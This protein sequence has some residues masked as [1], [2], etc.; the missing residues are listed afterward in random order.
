M[1]SLNSDIKGGV[2]TYLLNKGAVVL[3]A[4]ILIVQYNLALAY[5]FD[6][7]TYNILPYFFHARLLS[8]FAIRHTSF[9]YLCFNSTNMA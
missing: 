6:L 9:P 5:L 1:I 7:I 2:I 4:L 8:V 3:K